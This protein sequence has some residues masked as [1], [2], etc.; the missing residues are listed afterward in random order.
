MVKMKKKTSA[1]PSMEASWKATHFLKGLLSTCQQRIKRKCTYSRRC[2]FKNFKI[3]GVFLFYFRL[4]REE[5]LN[6]TGD[7]VGLKLSEDPFFQY[8]KDNRM[9]REIMIKPAEEFSPDKII[10]L[11][12][13]QNIGIDPASSIKP[14]LRKDPST[15]SWEEIKR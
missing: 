3:L 4:S 11:A 13:R 8:I 15:M 12:L 10:F 14:K 1:W 6:P 9:I 5:I 7:K 2:D